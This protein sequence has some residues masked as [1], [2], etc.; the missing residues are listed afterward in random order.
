MMCVRFTDRSTPCVACHRD[1]RFSYWN[2]ELGCWIENDSTAPQQVLD[3]LPA[4]ER[5]RVMR[6]MTVAGA[7]PV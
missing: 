6:A 7:V 4:D 1:G 2:D 3:G 5:Q